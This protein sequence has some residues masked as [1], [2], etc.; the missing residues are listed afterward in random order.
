[1]MFKYQFELDT[2]IN[3]CSDCDL[4]LVGGD[5]PNHNVLCAI[6]GVKSDDYLWVGAKSMGNVR[7]AQAELFKQCPLTK[8]NDN[9]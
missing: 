8:V 1:M 6:T 9:G 3:S 5:S 7:K 4:C 2:E